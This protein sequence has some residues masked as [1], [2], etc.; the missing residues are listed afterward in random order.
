MRNRIQVDGDR[1]RSGLSADP[2]SRDWTW[3]KRM[4]RAF[5]ALA[6]ICLGGV[7]VVCAR[8]AFTW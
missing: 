8:M 6:C 5:A 1:R 7:I 4:P 3:T 2:Y